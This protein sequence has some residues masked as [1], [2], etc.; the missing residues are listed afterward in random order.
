[1]NKEFVSI[2]QAP[3][4]KLILVG[5]DRYLLRLCP[6]HIFPGEIQQTP[7][8]SLPIRLTIKWLDDYFSG[9]NPPA[10]TLPIRL[11]G[12]TF[13]EKCWMLLQKIPYGRTVTYKDIA[14]E[15]SKETQSGKMSCQAVGQA[16]GKNP[17][18]IIVPCH[19]VIGSNGTLTGYAGGLDLKEKLLAIENEK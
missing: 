7:E 12:T 10:E 11:H 8:D 3:I 18:A 2:Y 1:M 15:L 16:I 9:Q 14:E 5:D 4:G 6:I 19:R 13:Q 17:I